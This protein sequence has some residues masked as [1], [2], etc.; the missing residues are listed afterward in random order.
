MSEILQY[1]F[2]RIFELLKQSNP[3]FDYNQ[4][5]SRLTARLS[6]EMSKFRHRIKNP[7][8]YTGT[9]YDPQGKF[10]IPDELPIDEEDIIFFSSR[11]VEC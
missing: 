1:E 11:I 6:A 10:R 5:E 7:E 9:R 4:I 3:E 2:E 8:L